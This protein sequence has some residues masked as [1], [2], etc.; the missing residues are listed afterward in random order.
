LHRLISEAF[1][2][3]P[4][5]KLCIDHIDNNTLNNNSINN[6]RWVTTKE[7]AQN[8]KLSAK[9]TSGFKGVSFH[10]KLNKWRTARHHNRW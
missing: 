9:N 3:N 10:K 8:A 1:I 2:P 4:D 7:N 5:N 6:L